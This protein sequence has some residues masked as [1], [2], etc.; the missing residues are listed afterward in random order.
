MSHR[1]DIDTGGRTYIRTRAHPYFKQSFWHIL[2]IIGFFLA[3]FMLKQKMKKTIPASGSDAKSI[4]IGLEACA[5]VWIVRG[6]WDMAVRIHFVAAWGPHLPD[7][8]EEIEYWPFRS[9]APYAYSYGRTVSQFSA[10]RSSYF[11][12]C[13]FG[14]DLSAELTHSRTADVTL[15]A[16]PKILNS[17]T[18][19]QLRL[20]AWP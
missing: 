14:L 12:L 5:P 19:P 11:L 4:S 18:C 1:V 15:K 2:I 13:S 8:D 9:C 16:A 20:W 3:L 6:L 10:I 17:W 7:I